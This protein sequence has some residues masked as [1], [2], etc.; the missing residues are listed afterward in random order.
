MMPNSSHVIVTTES[1]RIAPVHGISVHHRVFPEV[2][3]G[4]KSAKDAAA[5]L[6]ELLSMTLDN[7]SNDWRGEMI[8][9]AIEDVRAFAEGPH[10][11]SGS[12]PSV[13]LSPMVFRNW[14]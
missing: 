2:R 8:L 4:G 9:E 13:R 6:A 5:R 3:G 1:D 11:G 10:S 14:T 12:D 7:A